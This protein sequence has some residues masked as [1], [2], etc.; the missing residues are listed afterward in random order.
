MS[1]QPRDRDRLNAALAG[2]YRIEEP[3]GEGGMATVYLARDLRHERQVALKV[4][5]PEIAAALGEQRFLREIQV[6]ASLHHPHVLPLFDSG[7]ADGVLFYV[8]PLMRG[9]SLRGRLAREKQLPIEETVRILRQVAGA[10]DYAHR[11]GIIHRDIKPENILIQDGEALI[12][13]FGIALATAEGGAGRLTGTGLSM[14]T[15]QY[16]SPEQALADRDLDAR[17]DVYSLSW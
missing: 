3:L 4:L 11:Q 2:R 13:D 16:M 10:L 12:A 17:S 8:M 7:S 14:G 5:K 6:T 1:E 9:E 15:V